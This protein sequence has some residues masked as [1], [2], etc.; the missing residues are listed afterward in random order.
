MSLGNDD[1][2][3]WQV[4]HRIAGYT[5]QCDT[6][7]QTGM[8]KPGCPVVQEFDGTGKQV[9][10]GMLASALWLCKRII[11]LAK[12]CPAPASGMLIGKA[13]LACRNKDDSAPVKGS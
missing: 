5:G 10:S 6:I 7:E 3:C 8:S 9:H 2:K 1:V 4:A 12:V 13:L 11:P